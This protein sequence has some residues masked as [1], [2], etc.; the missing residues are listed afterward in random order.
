MI[1]EEGRK[2]DETYGPWPWIVGFASGGFIF[3]LMFALATGFS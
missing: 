2:A 1:G 3:W